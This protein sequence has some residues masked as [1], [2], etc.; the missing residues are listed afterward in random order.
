MGTADEGCVALLPVVAILRNARVHGGASYCGYVAPEVE[1][2][3]NKGF[4]FGA[5]LG[6]LDIDPDDRHVR[7]FGWAD[8]AGA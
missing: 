3:V 5:V 4:S 2:P 1:R 7:V 6:V 8:D